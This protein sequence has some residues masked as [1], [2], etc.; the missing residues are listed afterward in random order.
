MNNRITPV[1]FY[2]R[3]FLYQISEFSISEN[4]DKCFN[5]L[6]YYIKNVIRKARVSITNR[7]KVV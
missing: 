6:E 3:L 4:V 7:S 5:K 1:F 2:V